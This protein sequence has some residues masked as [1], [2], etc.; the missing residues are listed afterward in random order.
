MV[1]TLEIDN[2]KFKKALLGY[3]DQFRYTYEEVMEMTE[4]DL[5][6]IFIKETGYSSIIVEKEYHDCALCDKYNRMGG[7]NVG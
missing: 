3:T 1:L 7:L 4:E 5:K 6:K 2:N